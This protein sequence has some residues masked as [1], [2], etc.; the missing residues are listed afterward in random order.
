MELGEDYKQLGR[1][2]P[3]DPQLSMY[4]ARLSSHPRSPGSNRAF[5]VPRLEQEKYR[6]I[7][8]L[9]LSLHGRLPAPKE[10]HSGLQQGFGGPLVTLARVSHDPRVPQFLEEPCGV[11]SVHQAALVVLHLPLKLCRHER[12]RPFPVHPMLRFGYPLGGSANSA[13]VGSTSLSKSA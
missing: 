3:C 2:P 12:H 7:E 8:S 4:L 5:P 9:L 10:N 13:T 1:S 11:V 6:I